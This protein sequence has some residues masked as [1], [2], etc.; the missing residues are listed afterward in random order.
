MKTNSIINKSLSDCC[1]CGSCRDVCPKEAISMVADDEGFLYPQVS[2]DKCI[3]CGLCT[4]KCPTE[5][6]NLTPNNHILESVCGK[7]DNCEKVKQTSS[8]GFC[9]A[10]A[11]QF[12]ESGGVVY[13]AAYSQDYHTVEV[14]RIDR[15]E[16]LFKV[17]GS[18]YVQTIKP[19]GIFKEIKEDI[20]NNIPVLFISVPCDVAAVKNHIGNSLLLTT[21]EII[22]SGVPSPLVH[23]QFV[24]HLEEK[25]NCKVT[26]FTY[27]KKQHGWHWPYVE[28]K[29]NDRVIYNKSWSTMALGYAFLTLVRPSCYRCKFKGIYNKADITAG[30]FWGLKKSDSRYNKNG[31]SAV[32][33]HTE[34]GKK[35]VKQLQNFDFS[36]ATY[37]EILK[38]NP[39]LVSCPSQRPNRKIFSDSFK[40]YGLLKAYKNCMTPKDHLKNIVMSI[41]SILNLR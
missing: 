13:G 12:I 35:L 30:D 18:K 32:I 21:I 6:N 2:Q 1:G 40:K 25:K 28:A 19:S 8:G 20:K 37:E 11:Y 15:K 24:S 38:G 31:V 4:K 10:A 33:I 9:D 14:I 23:T 3:N 39:R 16:D 36:P 34:R 41:Y 22:C 5:Q 7:Y 29:S 27:R 17:R 26:G